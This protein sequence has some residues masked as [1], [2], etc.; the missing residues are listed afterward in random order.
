[1][2][3]DSVHP[4]VHGEL[5][6]VS[7]RVFYVFGSSP[8]TRG[9][10]VGAEPL[11]HLARFIPAYTGNSAGRRCG[12]RHSTVH[13]RVHGELESA[14]ITMIPYAGSSPRT[15]GTPVLTLSVRTVIRFIPAYTGNSCSPRTA[16]RR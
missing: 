7:A 12:W 15:R 2:V 1:M 4:R 16:R 14:S 8:R 6:L 9:T 11:G 3:S 5:G 10:R 13:P